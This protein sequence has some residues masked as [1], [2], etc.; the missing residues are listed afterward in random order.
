MTQYFVQ[1][2]HPEWDPC[3]VGSVKANRA[4]LPHDNTGEWM[5]KFYFYF[6]K[7][8]TLTVIALETYIDQHKSKICN[9]LTRWF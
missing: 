4:P 7:M 3:L 2:Y 9:L 5:V 6:L 8:L 1:D